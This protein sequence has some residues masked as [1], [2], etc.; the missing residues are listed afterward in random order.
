[1]A[2]F[3]NR[4]ILAAIAFCMVAGASI[5]AMAQ[6]TE[7]FISAIREGDLSGVKHQIAQGVN[8]NDQDAGALYR[9]AS[10]GHLEIVK[11]LV[12]AGADVNLDSIY[13]NRGSAIRI[14][15]KNRQ[16]ETVDYLLSVGADL[17]VGGEHRGSTLTAAVMTGKL[18]LVKKVVA[19]G[20]ANLDFKETLMRS[21]D[22]KSALMIAATRDFS[23]IVQFL[24]AHGAKINLARPCGETALYYAA[25]RGS[26]RVVQY[27]LSKGAVV[28]PATPERCN[29]PSPILVAKGTEVHRLLLLAGADPNVDPG[30]PDYWARP[31]ARAATVCDHALVDLLI[32]H[33]AIL[34]E[35]LKQEYAANCKKAP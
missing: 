23:D 7:A 22:G 13:G 17:R 20:K 2:R 10:A 18:D 28:N 9:A 15:A 12:Q 35:E 3:F 32:A 8:V 5:G 21:E 25:K 24:G 26:V 29:D 27:L 1:M 19:G 16:Y 14:A 11:Y 31:I 4:S 30:S 34:D 6:S 33:N